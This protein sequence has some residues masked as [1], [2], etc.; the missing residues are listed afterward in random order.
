MTSSGLLR[1]M[2]HRREKPRKKLGYIFQCIEIPDHIF[3]S[4]V[5]IPKVWALLRKLPHVLM[6]LC[7]FLKTSMPSGM[8]I[9]WKIMTGEE[10]TGSF[11]IYSELLSWKT[12]LIFPL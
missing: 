4:L 6:N 1:K 9:P 5:S 7:L 11:S 2:C 10:E 12:A 8:Q 3:L